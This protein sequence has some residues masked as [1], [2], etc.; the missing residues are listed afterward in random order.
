[1]VFNYIVNSEAVLPISLGREQ[2][3]TLEVAVLLPLTCLSLPSPN[4][5]LKLKLINIKLKKISQ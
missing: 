4:D 1:M 3:K 5:F 2:R